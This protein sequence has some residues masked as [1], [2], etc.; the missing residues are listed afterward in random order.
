[1]D[2]LD[3]ILRTILVPVQRGQLILPSASM[4]EVLPFAP[5]KPVAD[6][7]EWVLGCMAWRMTTLPVISID[8]LVYGEPAEPGSRS[9][10]AVL[11]GIGA[12]AGVEHFAVLI[13]AVPRLVTLER[14]L[15][16]PDRDVVDV[17]A[18][19]L[20]PVRIARQSAYIP[21]LEYIE[22]ALCSLFSVVGHEHAASSVG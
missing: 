19:M 5:P 1:M 13:Q 17:P 15:I 10:V 21:D 3:Q 22:R 11:T 20:T 18:G 12:A 9:R 4:V 6:A 7:P 14:K 2:Q 16:E 8:T